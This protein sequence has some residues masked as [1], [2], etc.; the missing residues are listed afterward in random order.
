MSHYLLQDIVLILALSMLVTLLFQRFR[1]PP[2]IGFLAT[3]IIAG[4]SVLSLTHHESNTISLSAEIGVIM[5]MFLIGMEIS[6]SQIKKMGKEILIGGSLQMITSVVIIALVGIAFSLP[7]NTAIFVGFLLALSSTAI[8][9]K[10]LQDRGEINTPHGKVIT[11]ILVFQ[12]IAAIPFMLITPSLAGDMS[13]IWYEIGVAIFKLFLSVIAVWLLSKYVVPAFMFRVAKTRRKELFLLSVVFICLSVTWISSLVGISVA[14]G[15]FMAGLIISESDYSHQAASNI[16]PFRQIFTNLFFVSVGTLLDV[17]YLFDHI[18]LVLSA[19]ALLFLVNVITGSFSV[20]LL[21]YP[22]RTAFISGL[23]LF[24]V[25]EFSFILAKVGLDSKVIDFA[26]YQKF[27]SV[28]V[29]TMGLTPIVM[30]YQEYICSIFVRSRLPKIIEKVN[31]SFVQA[32][33][34]LVPEKNEL[35]EHIVIIGFG[36]TGKNIAIAAKASLIP[37]VIVEINPQTVKTAQKNGEPIIFGIG[38]ADG[39]MDRVNIQKARVVVISVSDPKTTRQIISNIRQMNP[40][41]DII[42]KTRHLGEVRELYKL[43]ATQVIPAD[44]ETAVQVFAKV[45]G[46]YN[47]HH[48]D[49]DSYIQ[50]IREQAYHRYVI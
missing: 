15:A 6:I 41:L 27:L 25:G 28:S 12:D 43:G 34:N 26:L 17:N 39:I 36:I 4:P 46:M 9:L 38:N 32:S 40:K 14:L 42:V 24:Q 11:A 22:A 35:E 23:A 48:D 29:I 33:E 8:V 16:L 13:G 30:Q 1:M 49:I 18:G 2:I 45:L 19:V 21:R 31:K 10:V 50:T 5:L 7:V 47:L 44:L 37:Y 3:G 20:L